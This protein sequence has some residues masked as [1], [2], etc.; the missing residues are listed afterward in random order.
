MENDHVIGGLVR[1]RAEIDAQLN[2]AELRVVQSRTDLAAIE[3]ALKVLD[4]A[5]V[6]AAIR[7]KRQSLG[8]HGFPRGE[9]APSSR[10]RR[11]KRTR[12]ASLHD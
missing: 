4:P 3:R 5:A 11:P 6:P 9:F 12:A 2:E 1:K 10:L 7:P 8:T